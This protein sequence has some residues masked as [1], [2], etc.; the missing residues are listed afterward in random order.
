MLNRANRTFKDRFSKMNRLILGGVSCIALGAVLIPLAVFAQ[1][2]K[3]SKSLQSVQRVSYVERF[4][5][6]DT[7]KDGVVSKSEFKGK[8]QFFDAIDSN[9]DGNLTKSEL[10]SF[11]KSR[12]KT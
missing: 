11:A 2:A 9:K 12:T 8:T 10:A 6:I 4:N 7:N 5:Q 1:D 3:I